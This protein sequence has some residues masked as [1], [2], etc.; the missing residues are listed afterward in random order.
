MPKFNV[1]IYAI[2]RVTVEGV[3]AESPEAAAKI[4]DE[5][6]DLHRSCPEV[7]EYADSVDGYMVDQ[8]N[9]TGEQVFRSVNLT[10]EL[11]R[12]TIVDHM[13]RH[14]CRFT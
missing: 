13:L 12:E 7:G 1:H 5:K 3:E 4:A 2:V 9:D 10:A 6:T 14:T 8:V 11:K